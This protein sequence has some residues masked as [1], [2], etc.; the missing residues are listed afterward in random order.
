M[1]HTTGRYGPTDRARPLGARSQ[2]PLGARDATSGLTT[3]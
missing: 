2:V 1:N 3:E